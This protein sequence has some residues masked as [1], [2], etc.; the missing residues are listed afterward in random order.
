M[1]A[2][3]FWHCSSSEGQVPPRYYHVDVHQLASNDASRKNS[4]LLLCGVEVLVL[5]MV[6]TN[7]AR[8]RMEE[9]YLLLIIR[10]ETP[11][12]QPGLL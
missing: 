12:S 4:S 6:F 2:G 1:L 8:V 3:F 10:G 7:I 9:E 5:H 11:D